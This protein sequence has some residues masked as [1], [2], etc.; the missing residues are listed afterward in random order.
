MSA[1]VSGRPSASAHRTVTALP[2]RKAA[3]HHA[4]D[5]PPRPARR[6]VGTPGPRGARRGAAPVRLAAAVHRRPGPRP[7]ARARQRARDRVRRADAGARA[8]RPP[9]PP[10]RRGHRPGRHR[11]RAGAPRHDRR[12]R[13]APHRRRPDDP[14]RRGRRLR[15]LDATPTTCCPRSAG[16]PTSRSSRTRCAPRPR[17]PRSSPCWRSD[18]CS[19]RT[20]PSAGPAAWSTAT[21]RGSTASRRR[22]APAAPAS[23]T[24]ARPPSSPRHRAP[25]RRTTGSRS[26]IAPV[27]VQQLDGL[28]A[29]PAPSGGAGAPL[30]ARPGAGAAGRARPHPA[31]G[32]RVEPAPRPAAAQRARSCSGSPAPPSR[33]STGS[34]SC[35]RPRSAWPSEDVPR[36]I[37]PCDRTIR[38][39]GAFVLG[40]LKGE[41]IAT[42]GW[43]FYAGH[44]LESPDGYRI[45]ALCLLDTQVA[46]AAHGRPDRARGGRRPDR[47]GALVRGRLPRTEDPQAR[48]SPARCRRR[49]ARTPGPTPTRWCPAAST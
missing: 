27:L 15:R 6:P 48:A 10:A 49:A 9:R 20:R 26:V 7:G 22:S 34:A 19:A 4:G 33:S 11:R 3:P 1:R 17:R 30:A 41:K 47:V 32:V 42:D 43:R 29:K 37:A 36:S 21:P 5:R 28:A 16:A 12:A 39:N 24:S 31:A 38:Q 45:G 44:P 25:R 46:R 35:S 2:A 14:L 23:C 8:A 13:P 18:R 40:D